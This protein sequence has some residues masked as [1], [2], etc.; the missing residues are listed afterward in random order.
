MLAENLR[1][2]DAHEVNCLGEKP[3]KAIWRSYRKSF[4]RKTA[5]IDGK[6]AA[7]WGM[8][9]TLISNVGH[10]WLLT[11][12]IVEEYPLSFVKVYKK[13]VTKMLKIVPL[14][15]NIVDASYDKSVKMLK[16]AGFSIGEPIPVGKNGALF[17]RFEIR[18]VN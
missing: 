2:E 14:L 10:P 17:R 5:F 8:T 13:E 1:K 12:D 9:G 7:M 11:A 18:A 3:Y 4:I 6:I 16:L 15:E